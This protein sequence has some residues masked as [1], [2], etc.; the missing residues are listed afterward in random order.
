[1][2]KAHKAISKLPPLQLSHATG[3]QV[4]RGMMMASSGQHEIKPKY[5]QS[6]MCGDLFNHLSFFPM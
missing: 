2:A 3:N 5:R 6:C 1:M 4:S